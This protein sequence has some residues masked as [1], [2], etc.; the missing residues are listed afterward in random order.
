[1]SK[2]RNKRGPKLNAIAAC[3]SVWGCGRSNQEILT[4]ESKQISSWIGSAE[5]VAQ[6]WSQGKV[7]TAYA[8]RS[9]ETFDKQLRQNAENL[10]SIADNRRP[11]FIATVE[12]LEHGV[13]EL[14][15]AVKQNNKEAIGRLC[16]QLYERSK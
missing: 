15:M 2:A 13:A 10:Q 11:Q 12:Q 16:A 4:D 6:A 14:D 8:H 3:L 5:L 1:M 7:P 9:L